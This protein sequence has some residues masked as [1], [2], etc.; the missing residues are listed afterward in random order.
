MPRVLPMIAVVTTLAATGHF[1]SA[2]AAAPPARRPV[3]AIRFIGAKE[4][5]TFPFRVRLVFELT[6]PTNKPLGFIGF[7][8]NSFNPPIPKG[9]AMPFWV[10]DL[11]QAGKITDS[12]DGSGGCGYG[13]GR[14]EIQA[15]SSATFG[16]ALPEGGWDDMVVR[17]PASLPGE[18]E[19]VVSDTI[20]RK[21]IEKAWKEEKPR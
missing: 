15:R 8:A 9:R 21:Q 12:R 1:F 5:D 20:T 19:W 3:P 16:V 6:N 11:R 17:I 14:V 4:A 2:Q 18:S 7:R 10:A 13:L